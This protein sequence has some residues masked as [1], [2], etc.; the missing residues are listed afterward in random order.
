MI[1]KF[2]M[3]MIALAVL[4][5]AA[6]FGLQHWSQATLNKPLAL[7]A[8]STADEGIKIDMLKGSSLRQVPAKLAAQGCLSS[9]HSQQLSYALRWQIWRTPQL[10]QVKAGEYLLEDSISFTQLMDKM[11]RG[12]V[13]KYSVTIVEGTRFQ[14]LLALL[15]TLPTLQHELSQATTEEVM[16]RLGKAGEHPEGWFAPD[17]YFYTKQDTDLAILQRALQ[18]QEKHLAE[19]WQSKQSD[20][21][22]ASPYEA[23]IMASIIERETGVAHERAQI[24]G[25]F[26][27]RLEQGMRLQTDPTVIYGMGDD[28]TGRITRADLR[29]ATPY[30]TYVIHGLPPT[31]IALPSTAA[32]E[33]A[34]NPAPGK[35]LYFVA[36]GDGSHYFS[37][38]YEEHTAAVRRYQLQRRSDY[39]SSPPVEASE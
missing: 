11:Q 3:V 38:T 2:F 13:V 22:Y 25:V 1:K 28:Y 6:W 36:K 12:A 39:R 18:A 19:L 15:T 17:T 33:A 9:K 14:D 16:E 5:A 8:C 10:A 21:P 4:A 27:R 37:A 31:P 29:T 35:A 34:L 7:H 24:A 30:N 32:I 26:V 20:L 23:L